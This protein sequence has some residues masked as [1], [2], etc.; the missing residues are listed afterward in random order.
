MSRR[1]SAQDSWQKN[2]FP[3]LD[4]K[5]LRLTGNRRTVTE[6]ARQRRGGTA[7]EEAVVDAGIGAVSRIRWRNTLQNRSIST[8]MGGESRRSRR[9]R[10]SFP[11]GSTCGQCAS[12]YPHHR[13]H[14][15]PSRSPWRLRNRGGGDRFA[16]SVLANAGLWLSASGGCAIDIKPAAPKGDRQRPCFGC[17]PGWMAKGMPDQQP[18]QDQ[19]PQTHAAAE[20]ARAAE[21]GRRS[22][23]AVMTNASL[24]RKPRGPL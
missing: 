2:V 5:A 20:P 24:P 4:G 12:A 21:H 23:T 13:H 17:S 6:K 22:R 18:E 15:P 16:A 7:G 14:L 3:I 1:R 8:G 9:L 19:E 11:R 10:T